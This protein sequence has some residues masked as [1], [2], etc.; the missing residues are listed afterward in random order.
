M[1]KEK[2]KL[3]L[4][5]AAKGIQKNPDPLISEDY[6]KL[7]SLLKKEVGLTLT[8]Q[9][10]N[11]IIIEFICCSFQIPIEEFHLGYR[12]QEEAIKLL[13]ENRE[14]LNPKIEEIISKSISTTQ[15]T[16]LVHSIVPFILVF[17]NK[18]FKNLSYLKNNKLNHI[19]CNSETVRLEFNNLF[20]RVLTDDEFL[21]IIESW[22][23]YSVIAED[24]EQ[25]LYFIGQIDE[26]RSNTINLIKNKEKEIAII[27]NMITQ[28]QSLS[29][30][31]QM[32]MTKLMAIRHQN[33]QQ[34]L[35]Y[36]ELEQ[37][38]KLGNGSI[39]N[40]NNLVRNG[41]ISALFCAELLG[42]SAP[43]KNKDG[44]PLITFL[45]I[46][47][48][49]SARNVGDQGDIR[50]RLSA[51]YQNYNEFKKSTI[52]IQQSVKYLIEIARENRNCIIKLRSLHK[53]FQSRLTQISQRPML[54]FINN[55]T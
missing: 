2:L 1:A 17:N 14:D 42:L 32:D 8:N 48:G 3:S 23:G 35:H 6:K 37:S 22:L 9:Q 18:E 30:F 24:S 28:I 21:L 53:I 16:N 44:N 54:N 34:L 40:K 45:D 47:L 7:Q 33:E 50:N 19:L 49:L 27:N 13:L 52:E 4:Y 15:Y 43:E 10:I 29:S 25:N 20:N 46:L 26:A 31:I 36:K 51:M 41:Y 38:L 55:D 12:T 39:L 5:L 11:S